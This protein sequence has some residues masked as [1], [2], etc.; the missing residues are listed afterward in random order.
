MK[1]ALTMIPFD[2]KYPID[3]CDVENKSLLQEYRNSRKL[4]VQFLSEDE[5]AIWNQIY[6]MLWKD[7]VFRV[8]NEGLRISAGNSEDEA[9]FNG[10]LGDFIKEGY[11]TLQANA[12]RKITEPPPKGEKRGIIS[13]RRLLIDIKNNLHLITRE[14]YVAGDGLP[15]DYV[16]VR[17]AC[18]EKMARIKQGGAI[19]TEGPQA[20]GSS[21]RAHQSFDKLSGTDSKKRS[22][23]DI[24]PI[25]IIE[26]LEKKL[27]A[28]KD[29]AVHTNKLINHASDPT[30]RA[31]LTEDQKTLSM[32][33]LDDCYQVICGVAKYV[34]GPLLW[35]GSFGMLPTPQYNHLKHLDKPLVKTADLPT[36]HKVWDER[37]ELIERWSFRD[38]SDL[39]YIS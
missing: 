30:S 2:F 31:E 33:K 5:H 28:C 24:I 12:V 37:K 7:S 32:K 35:L 18:L 13:L 9:E 20:W 4:W 14:N 15:Y 1:Q 8:F 27:D 10:A 16:P 17:N 6:D 11:V 25:S 29:T 34:S 38:W 19:S 21:E 23:T 3:Q 22:R 39:P 36:L 26:T